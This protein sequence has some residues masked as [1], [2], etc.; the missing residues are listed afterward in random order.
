MRKAPERNSTIRSGLLLPAARL[1]S[2]DNRQYAYRAIRSAILTL[3]LTP[4][5]KLREVVLASWLNVSRTPVHDAIERLRLE[6]LVVS[7]PNRI[8]TVACMDSKAIC[9]CL[10]LLDIFCT[11]VISSFFTERIPRDQIEILSFILQHV[12]ETAKASDG[13]G[14]ARLVHDF[15][16]QFFT[17]GGRYGLVWTGIVRTYSDMYRLNVMIGRD[18]EQAENLTRILEDMTKALAERDSDLAVTHMRHWLNIIQNLLPDLERRY[19]EYWT[20]PEG[21][22]DVSGSSA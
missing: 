16:Q 19:P 4:Q 11:E 9:D 12:R 14:Y 7:P 21:E 8:A 22:H 5:S 15:L 1:A 6:G 20:P 17:L 2:E 13:S 3:N 10:W 18:K